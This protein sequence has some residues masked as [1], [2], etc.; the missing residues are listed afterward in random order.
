MIREAAGRIRRPGQDVDRITRPS[1]LD[2]DPFD[3]AQ[4]PSL[5]SKT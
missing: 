4:M 5:L 1:F 3:A 2:T